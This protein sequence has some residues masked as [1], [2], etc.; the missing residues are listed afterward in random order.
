MDLSFLDLKTQYKRI[1]QSLDNRMAAVIKH[2]QF[3]MGPEVR[4]LEELLE[5]F[6]G[7][8]HCI[9]CSSG[10]DALLMALLALGIETGDEVV[11]TPF[12]F[13]ATA[14]TISLLGAR[15]AYSAI[16]SAIETSGVVTIA[17][18]LCVRPP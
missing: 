7:A 9:A 10:T 2:G 4:E 18:L 15:P 6:S 13:I 1:Q 3:I 11:T 14:E 16:G 5:K 12:T 17:V 8:N